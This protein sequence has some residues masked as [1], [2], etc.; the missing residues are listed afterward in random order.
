MHEKDGS[1]QK[2]YSEE[3]IWQVWSKGITAGGNDPVMWRKDEFGAWMLRGA[4][5]NRNSEFGWVID[6]QEPSVGEDVVSL[7]NLRPMHW[8]N[9]L[10]GE[11]G[12]PKC[13]VTSEGVHNGKPMENKIEVANVPYYFII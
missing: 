12:T 7:S 3:T 10:R 13:S 11:D 4:Y 8:K 9:T 1:L 6:F 2:R 5:E